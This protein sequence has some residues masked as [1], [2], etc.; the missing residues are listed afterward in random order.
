MPA[1][2]SPDYYEAEKHYKEARTDEERIEALQ[3]MLAVIPKHKGTDKMQADLKH[4]I[5]KLKEESQKKKGAVKQK[6]MFFIESEG[7]A[8]L[9]IIGPPNTGKSSLVATLTNASPEI[10]PFSHT[11]H[12]PTPGMAMFEN[13]QFQ[14]I[15]TPPM[16]EEYVDPQMIDMIRRS[17]ILVI[18][19]D[20]TSDLIGQYEYIVSELAANRIFP[21]GTDLE[22]G[23][24]RPAMFKKIIVL[25][26]KVDARSQIEDFNT[27][28][29]LV[30]LKTPT[31]PISILNNIN[32]NTFLKTVFDLSRI[33]RVYSKYPGREPDLNEPFVIP[34]DSTL[35]DLAGKIHKDFLTKLKFARVWGKSAHSGQM[36]QRDHVLQDGDIVELHI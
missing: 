12:K 2:L 3:E 19:L 32:L 1:N 20:I 25:V 29:E 34:R 8:Q 18:L 24:K 21:E 31:I 13:V 28:T 26:N 10:S 16:T 15:D 27:F 5:S 9:L 17:D 35:E 7:A 33:I 4:R 30:D 23:V 22:E 6:S 36:I 11:T 14:L